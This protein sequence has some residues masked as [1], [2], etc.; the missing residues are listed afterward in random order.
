MAN[1]DFEFESAR[2]GMSGAAKTL[3]TLTAGAV[4]GAI[5]ALLL[6]PQSGAETRKSI[7][8]AVGGWKDDLDG[9]IQQSVE[10][11]N[12]LRAN[13]GQEAH[14]AVNKMAQGNGKLQTAAQNAVKSSEDKA[15]GQLDRG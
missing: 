12:R 8:K 4:A 13:M 6:A 2:S 14:E 3:L 9:T 15:A 1:R 7:G 5:T 10:K 11:I